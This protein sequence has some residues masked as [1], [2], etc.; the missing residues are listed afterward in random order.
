MLGVIRVEG[1][2]EMGVGMF[3]LAE[4]AAATTLTAPEPGQYRLFAY[5]EDDHGRVA[6]ANLP[7]LVA[8]EAR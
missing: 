7:F 8:G 2:T 4:A 3:H 5:A 1:D 6:H